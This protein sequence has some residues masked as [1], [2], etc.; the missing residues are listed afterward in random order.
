MGA[1]WA[2]LQRC[3]VG[4]HNS[5]RG[6]WHKL[7]RRNTPQQS[8]CWYYEPFLIVAHCLCVPACVYVRCRKCGAYTALL[9]RAGPSP[10]PNLQDPSVFTRHSAWLN[11]TEKFY[12]TF[13]L[14]LNGQKTAPEF[15]AVCKLH[16]YFL[17]LISD[18]LSRHLTTW[19]WNRISGYESLP[20]SCYRFIHPSV[21]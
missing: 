2:Y 8:W 12:I 7:R 16:Y 21:K 15:V 9:M 18:E 17:P 1:W 20:P 14:I 3:F 6:I 19:G 13:F 5:W 4:E 11:T 10:C